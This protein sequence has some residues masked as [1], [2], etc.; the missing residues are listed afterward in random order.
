MSDPQKML[1]KHGKQTETLIPE[2]YLNNVLI[3]IKYLIYSIPNSI[4]LL[5][6]D[7]NIVKG[8]KILR[9]HVPFV[10]VSTTIM[11]KNLICSQGLK[12]KEQYLSAKYRI[13]IAK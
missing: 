1:L 10:H 2:V 11:F 6:I 8:Y 5:N 3:I 9:H 12:E 4:A 13:Y 7:V